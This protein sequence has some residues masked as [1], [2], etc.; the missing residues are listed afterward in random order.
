MLRVIFE[1]LSNLFGFGK[2]A[3]TEIA[4]RDAEKNTADQRANAEA[5]QIQ[6]DR[7]RARKEIAEGNSAGVDKDVSP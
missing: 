4:Q 6:A 3:S 1:F 2:A 7:D 5:A